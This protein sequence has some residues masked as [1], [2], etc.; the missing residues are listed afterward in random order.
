MS[1]TTNLPQYLALA[2]LA[3]ILIMILVILTPL[4]TH[5]PSL[6]DNT[7]VG[8][9]FIASCILGITFT[10]RPGW[11]RKNMKQGTSPLHRPLSSRSFQ[12]HHPN[13]IMFQ[14]HRLH[15]KHATWCAGCLGITIGLLLASGFAAFEL[16]T[17]WT[18]TPDLVWISAGFLLLAVAF[19]EMVLPHRHALVHLFASILLGPGL[20]ILVFVTFQHTGQSIFGLFVL[21]LEYLWM[22]TRI[23]I[24]HWNHARV[25]NGCIQQCKSFE[26]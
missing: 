21:L 12:G 8:V 7:I 14:D 5:P 9:L 22:D 16:I 1:H 4:T 24:S 20:A 25:C 2:M 19:V 11:M 10:Q 3:A 26:V 17:S 23:Q 18:L 6:F 15:G 13:C